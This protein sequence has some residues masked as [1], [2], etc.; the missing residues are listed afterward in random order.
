[1]QIQLKS[2]DSAELSC[3]VV[4]FVH[5][6]GGGVGLDSPRSIE[7]IASRKLAIL[8]APVPLARGPMLCPDESEEY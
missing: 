2:A 5:V 8:A 1:M 7:I 6:G 3:I 4:V